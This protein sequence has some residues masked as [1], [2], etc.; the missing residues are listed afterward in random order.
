MLCISKCE[1]KPWIF[2]NVCYVD[3]FSLTHWFLD[4]SVVVWGVVCVHWLQERPGHFV[5]LQ[6]RE[7]QRK[8]W[9]EVKARTPEE[10][11]TAPLA[12]Q[13]EQVGQHTFFCSRDSFSLRSPCRT[14]TGWRERRRRRK[15]RE[16]GRRGEREASKNKCREQAKK[17][18]TTLGSQTHQIR[19]TEDF[20]L[21]L[22]DQK[23]GWNMG[24]VTDLHHERDISDS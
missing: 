6:R 4:N 20:Y 14:N 15:S 11:Q 9:W 3:I 1:F 24:R 7:E 5:R 16:E 23:G 19:P 12:W 21:L 13:E 8:E 22:S 2:L 10:Q 17:K 18:K